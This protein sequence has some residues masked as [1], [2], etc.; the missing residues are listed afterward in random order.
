MLHR[1]SLFTYLLVI[2]LVC[3]SFVLGLVILTNREIVSDALF[4]AQEEKFSSLTRSATEEIGRHL[5]N[6]EETVS[7]NVMLFYQ[8]EQ[9]SREKSS[10]LLMHT[11]KSHPTICGMEIIFTEVGRKNHPDNDFDALYVWWEEGQIKTIDRETALDYQA[12]WFVKPCETKEPVWSE[13]YQ[14]SPVDILMVTYSF[15][16]LDDSGEVEA[17]FTADISFDWF[18]KRLLSLPLGK[19]GVPI[20]LSAEQKIIV[21]PNKD[22]VLHESLRSLAA[23]SET[24]KQRQAYV[25][26]SEAIISQGTGWHRFVRPVTGER[27][28]LYFNTLG[29][30]GWTIGCILPDQ[31]VLGVVSSMNRRTM[32][33]GF[34]GMLLLILPSWL[35][36]RSVAGPLRFLSVAAE[37]V[38]RGQF[39]VKLPEAHGEG[40]IA[41]LVS[42]FDQ[43]RADLARYVHDITESTRQRERINAELSVAH[44]IQLGMVPKDFKTPQAHG[45]DLFAMMEPAQEVGGDLYDFAMLDDDHLYFCIGDVSGKGIP[46]SLFMAIGKTLL[47]SS[48]QSIRDPATAMRLVNA[49]LMR[50]NDAS[51]FITAFCGIY[52]RTTG[53]II[54]ANAGHNPP[55][56]IQPDGSVQMLPVT[57]KFPLALDDDTDYENAA[58]TLAPGQILFLYTDGVTDAEN[59]DAAFFGEERLRQGLAETDH[60]DIELFARTMMSRVHTFAAGAKQ[61]DDIT[62]LTFRAGEAKETNA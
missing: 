56:L 1:F 48:I 53:Q 42:S 22:W 6:V 16:V 23:K 34:L 40:E 17:V 9:R 37:E 54:Y 45:V 29:K 32:L 61:S 52:E 14:D 19:S 46:A 50:H 36:A 28:W 55:A 31:Q 57:P 58:L 25:E 35:I 33:Y 20:L 7:Q 8:S 60:S 30:N 12:E 13:P 59:P 38:S 43:M 27:A 3:S 11:L 49:E 4:T 18:S 2:I 41:K 24:P 15:P 26:M 10:R 39:D 21:Y 44:S 47:K 62:L 51:L 5:E